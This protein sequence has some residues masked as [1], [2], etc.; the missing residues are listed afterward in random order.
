MKSAWYKISLTYLFFAATIGTLLRSI[1]YVP[2]PLEYGHLVHAHSHVAF[3]GWIY[4]LL[5]LLLTHFFI[6]QKQ[7][8]QR[9][10]SLQF[11]LTAFII[12]G[13]LLSFSLQGYALYSI[14]FST[15]F[16]LL[17][18]LKVKCN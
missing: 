15:L 4:T 13:V 2:L 9:R 5:F 11:K 3:Q 1:A 14:I 16:Q 10:Y 18:Y 6:D 8:L 17:N 7:V 12:L